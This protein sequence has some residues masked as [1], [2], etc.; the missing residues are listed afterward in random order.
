M[1]RLPLISMV[2][3]FYDK[4]KYLVDATDPRD[5]FFALLSIAKDNTNYNQITAYIGE[6][7]G[8]ITSNLV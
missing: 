6:N 8:E 4:K 1:K 2:G 3:T 5:R 7:N